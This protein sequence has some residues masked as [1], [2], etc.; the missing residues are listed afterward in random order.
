MSNTHKALLYVVVF[1]AGYTS[2]GLELAASRLLDPWFGNSIFVWASLIGLILLYLALGYWWG[3]RL[4]D[5][6]PQL[7]TLYSIAA[8]AAV[9]VALI[10]IVSRPVLQ[11]AA[12]IFI[13][14]DTTLLAGSFAATLALFSLPTIL[15]GMI[16]P[17]AIRMLVRSTDGAGQTAGQVFALSTIG[18]ILGVFVTVLLMI[19][20]LG[21]RR[22]FIA[23]G[24]LLL[25]WTVLAGLHLRLRRALLWLAI[26]LLMW[27][28][29]L[30]TLAIHAGAATLYE[31]ESAYNYIQVV[32]NGPEVVLKLNEGA[33]V[34]SV[35][36][37]GMR[38]TGGIWDYFLLAPYFSPAPVRPAD[39]DSLLLIGLA[40][41]TIPK[42]YTQVYGPIP[43][44]GVEIDPAIIDVGRR[45][46][47][48]TEPNLHAV[49]QDGRTFLQHSAGT[50]DVIAIDAY[51]PPYI[52]FH[53]T[54][55]EFFT[56]TRQHLSPDG[57]VAIN[58][59]RTRDDF[60][61]VDALA[62]T[63][64]QVYPSVFIID[65]PTQGADLG[66]SLIVATQQPSSLDDFR[67]NIAHLS[68]P[69][70]QELAQRA[71]PHARLAPVQGTVLRDDKAPIEQIVHGIVLRYLLAGG[72]D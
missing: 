34:H 38:L 6:H 30:P 16:S 32:S 56:E 70:L 1:I 54:T 24:L 61:L 19:P 63:L 36:R 33:G 69:I 60:R 10:P 55:L 7:A 35:Y 44:D 51:R 47:A 8:A 48:M 37:P 2:L 42:L 13:S 57:V 12:G 62:A 50:Y 18:S 14:Y 17:F 67:R 15:L 72:T 20:T 66:N 52:P 58:A 28:L 25:G 4:A 59:A 31:Q 53:L 64:A 22:T 49:A 11:M 40:A 45:Y 27:L 65:E 68:S 9:A 26:W 41:G 29:L 46:F 23:L 21:T 5:R 39:V 3:G 43:I 71:A